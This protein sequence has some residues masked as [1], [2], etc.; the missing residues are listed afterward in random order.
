MR[1]V[2]DKLPKSGKECVFSEEVKM[3]SKYKCAFIQGLYSRCRLDSEGECPYLKE[4][5]TNGCMY[6]CPT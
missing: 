1:V 2:V 3:T 4:E 5:A 6:H